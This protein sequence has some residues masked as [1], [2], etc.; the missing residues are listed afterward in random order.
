MSGVPPGIRR[1]SVHL[2][3]ATLVAAMGL[4][5][6]SLGRGGNVAPALPGGRATDMAALAPQLV[7]KQGADPV[8]GAASQ[9]PACTNA[10]LPGADAVL[11]RPDRPV[12]VAH[13]GAAVQIGAGAVHGATKITAE[14]L[15]ASGLAP[16]NQGM[17]NVTAGPRRGY[18][19]LPHMTFAANLRITLPYDPNLFPAGESAQD[20][21]TFHYDVKLRKWHAL[22]LVSV[23][24]KAHTVT[25]LTNHFT[26][27]AN[28]TITVPDHPGVLNNDPTSI[29]DIKA[30]DPAANINLIAPPTASSDGSAHLSYPIQ[31]PAGRH[32]QAPSLSLSYDSTTPNGSSG[33][34]HLHR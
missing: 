22:P 6:D 16:M 32:G 30:A 31:L 9:Q 18:R 12:S 5:W 23:D 33:P 19:F 8:T 11:A 34:A 14:S 27:F 20:L 15:C 26:D 29:K 21:R 10:T 25:S 2:V 3:V 17:A 13:D 1:I 7:A 4:N 24:Q 28:A